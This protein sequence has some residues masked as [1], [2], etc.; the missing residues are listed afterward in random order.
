MKKVLYPW[1][2]V[3]AFYFNWHFSAILGLYKEH[4]GSV[5]KFLTREGGAVGFQ[6]LR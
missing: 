4:S 2:Q 6:G 3:S 5:V 1:G